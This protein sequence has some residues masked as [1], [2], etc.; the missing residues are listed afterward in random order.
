MGSETTGQI[1]TENRKAYKSLVGGQNFQLLMISTG[2]QILLSVIIH[3][4]AGIL[5][6]VL[7]AL[8]LLG[9]FFA[10]GE[11]KRGVSLVKICAAIQFW[12]YAVF[13]GLCR[14]G[15]GDEQFLIG[16][17]SLDCAE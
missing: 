11:Q 6:Q 3:G 13:V 10:R 12:I 5:S 2:I 9:L 15:G 14:R 17:K 16:R 4:A 8:S 7:P 1:R